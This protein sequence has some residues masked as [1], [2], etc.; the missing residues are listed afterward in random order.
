MREALHRPVLGRPIRSGLEPDHKPSG[1]VRR[2]RPK[3]LVRGP[4]RPQDAGRMQ[5]IAR[6]A[7]R[8]EGVRQRRAVREQALQGRP[9]RDMWNL[10]SSGPRRPG[11]REGQRLQRR[12]EMREECMRSVWRDERHLRRHA[13]MQPDARVRGRFMR[14]SA[15]RRIVQ[16][17]RRMRR[18][19]RSL[20]RRK[21]VSAPPVRELAGPMWLGRRGPPALQRTS[22]LRRYRYRQGHV[23]ERACRQRAL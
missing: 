21:A 15:G 1:G 7:R 9:R 17:V 12:S 4:A 16:D 2:Y 10:H 13:S 14:R 20:L 3:P 19:P 6:S 23:R 22:V 8:W 5:G 11:V 18:D